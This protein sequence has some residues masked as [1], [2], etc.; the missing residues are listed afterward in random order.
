MYKV[1]CHIRTY[2]ALQL[3]LVLHNEQVFILLS[4]ETLSYV[5]GCEKVTDIQPSLLA[6]DKKFYCKL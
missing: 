6:Y 2:G 3:H 1:D 5:L 4:T